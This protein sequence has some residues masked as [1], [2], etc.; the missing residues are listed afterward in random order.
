MRGSGLVRETSGGKDHFYHEDS[1]T[2]ADFADWTGSLPSKDASPD[3]IADS[4]WQIF[5]CKNGV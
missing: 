3:V 2:L 5:G 1:T 4:P